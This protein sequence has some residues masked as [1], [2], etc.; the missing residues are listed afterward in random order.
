M[1]VIIYFTKSYC[2]EVDDDEKTPFFSK[3]YR[4]AAKLLDTDIINGLTAEDFLVDDDI[5][6][7]EEEIDE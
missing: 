2:V 6:N 3:A 7:E 5:A 1:K 4:K